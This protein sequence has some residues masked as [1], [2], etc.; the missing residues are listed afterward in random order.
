MLDSLFMGICL[1]LLFKVLNMPSQYVK[2][3][4]LGPL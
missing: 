2:F 4:D 1:V 3:G